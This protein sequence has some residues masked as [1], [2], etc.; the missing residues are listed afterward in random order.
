MIWGKKIAFHVTFSS[1]FLK[2]KKNHCSAPRHDACLF[3]SL[4]NDASSSLE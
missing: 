4:F 2:M 3:L 1:E